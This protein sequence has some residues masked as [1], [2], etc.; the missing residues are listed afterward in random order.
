MPVRKRL[1][2]GQF[3]WFLTQ[4][5]VAARLSCAQVAM[6]IAGLDWRRAIVRDKVSVPT[7]A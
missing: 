4:G 5:G 3:V 6:L 7:V 2:W 1:E